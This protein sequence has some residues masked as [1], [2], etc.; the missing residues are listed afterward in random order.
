MKGGQK[1]SQGT[2]TDHQCDH[3]RCSFV[4][5]ASADTAINR[6][7]GRASR[8]VGHQ[9]GVQVGG[10]LQIANLLHL[11]L[12]IV[13]KAAG[14]GDDENQREDEHCE[15]GRGRVLVAHHLHLIE[16]AVQ[17][18]QLGGGT[19]GH[20]GA[21]EHHQAE[22]GSVAAAAGRQ[23]RA[24]LQQVGLLSVGQGHVE[25]LPIV[26]RLVATTGANRLHRLHNVGSRR[27]AEI[28]EVG[29]HLFELLRG[30]GVEVLFEDKKAAEESD[31]DGGGDQQKVDIAVKK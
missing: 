27:V 24:V 22:K 13:L 16:A 23:L 4:A 14:T 21:I 9:A 15:G 29:H 25:V 28:T 20:G 30:T 2:T 26:G 12:A 6:L 31:Q 19:Q 3:A 7:I 5:S 8:I 10:V 11:Q 1:L 17:V 18:E